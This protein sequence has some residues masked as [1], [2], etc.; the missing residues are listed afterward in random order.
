MKVVA[1]VGSG[2]LGP[3]WIVHVDALKSSNIQCLVNSFYNYNSN[4]FVENSCS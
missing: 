2:D 3:R 1:G 4:S